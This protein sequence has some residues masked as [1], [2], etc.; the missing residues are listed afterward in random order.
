MRQD[1][2]TDSRNH[3]QA[4]PKRSRPTDP[5]AVVLGYFNFSSGAFDP[6]VWRAMNALFASVETAGEGDAEGPFA[7]LPDAA[8]RVATLLDRGQAHIF[9]AW[10]PPGGF[11]GW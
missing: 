9:S 6:A 4:D 8:A 11:G 3:P 7:E 10:P 2:P 1:F 5:A